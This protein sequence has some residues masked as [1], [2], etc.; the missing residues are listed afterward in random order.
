MMA[1]M[2]YEIEAQW[3]RDSDGATARDSMNYRAAMDAQEARRSAAGQDARL[4]L[5]DRLISSF[6]AS[7]RTRRGSAAR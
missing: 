7:A 2:G 1:G 4:G 3:R 6:Q 5:V